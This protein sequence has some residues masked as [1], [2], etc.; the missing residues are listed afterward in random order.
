[1]KQHITPKQL[2]ELSK[3]SELDQERTWDEIVE[4]NTRMGYEWNLT[5]EEFDR[6]TFDKCC[7]DSAKWTTIDKMKEFL[8]KRL[9][10]V[11]D[12][13]TYDKMS[14]QGE[15]LVGYYANITKL[16]SEGN[17]YG[18]CSLFGKTECDAL[19]EAIKYTLKN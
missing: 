15:D 16:D 19:W 8:G 3:W 12:T 9:K 13:I 10:G 2:W 1:M 18:V 14:P 7:E 17:L 5:K 4:F 11:E 6:Y